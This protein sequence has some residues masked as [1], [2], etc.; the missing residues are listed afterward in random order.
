MTL[1]GIGILGWFFLMVAASFVGIGLYSM[2]GDVEK[3]ARRSD[4]PY[5][6]ESVKA[7]TRWTSM[8]SISFGLGIASYVLLTKSLF[9]LGFI[10][11]T[12]GLAGFLVMLALSHVAGRR[13]MA[14]LERKYAVIECRM[15]IKDDDDDEDDARNAHDAFEKDDVTDW[16]TQYDEYLHNDYEDDENDHHMAA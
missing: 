2:F 12:V 4:C 15:D 14:V 7:A 9:T 13:A 16:H 1:F 11:F 10:N 3:L 6:V 8:S 5:T